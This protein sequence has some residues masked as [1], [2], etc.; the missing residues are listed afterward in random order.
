MDL[1]NYW[2]ENKRFLVTLSAG[3]IV[4][5]I[6]WMLIGKFFG[7]ELAAQ[8]RAADSTARKL[9]TE[10]MYGQTELEQAEALNKELRQASDE[11]SKLVAFQPRPPFVLDAKKGSASNQYFATVSTLREE[12]L[13]LASRANMRL[14]DDLGLP[15]LSPTREAEIARYLEALDL[16]E[17]AVRAALAAQVERID[18]IEI[19]LDPKLS[20]KQGVGS[21]EKTRVEM[22]LS[23][24]PAPLSDFLVRSQDAREPGPL[25]IEKC[26]MQPARN[27]VDEA[28]LDVTLIAA[29]LAPE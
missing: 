29:R 13:T 18:K 8:R 5:L 14:P 1:A 6:G 27:K 17:R 22:R 15:A 24:K 28:G 19:K 4:F 2:Q 16:V 26:E 20:S 9:A 23:G 25:L 11:L 3:V 12:L 10:A 21:I 7:G